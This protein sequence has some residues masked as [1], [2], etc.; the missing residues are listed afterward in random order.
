MEHALECYNLTEKEDQEASKI[1]IPETEGQNE[2]KGLELEIPD[3]MK[4]L[5]TKNP[6]MGYFSL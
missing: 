2:V 6:Q 4:P 5:K 3:M 1:N